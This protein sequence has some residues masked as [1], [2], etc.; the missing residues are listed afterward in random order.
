M[1]WYLAPALAVGR[2]EVNDRWPNRD[3]TSDGTIGDA[4]HQATRSDHNP[5]SRE[6]VDAW[7]MDVNG[8]NVWVVIDAFQDHPSAHYWIYDRQIATRAN[9]WRRQA[10]AGTNPHTQHVHF[11]VRQT[12]EA[13]QDR[14]SWGIWPLPEEDDLDATQAR[15]L[16][17]VHEALVTR[18]HA[19]AGG[20]NL[21]R[22]MEDLAYALLYG[23]PGTETT[24]VARTL[25]AVGEA[26][27][28]DAAEL[29]QI[30]G[31]VGDRLTTELLAALRVELADLPAD[32]VEVAAERA[33]RRVLG[34]LDAT[35]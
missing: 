19:W 15:Q 17:E 12:R 7:D 35:T 21:T 1:A 20:R 27:G 9:D 16:R 13:E 32:V 34:S 31:A 22:L 26:A 10:Y 18:K 29:E 6:S 4:A 11:S 28:L 5:N 23:L 14:R 33:V 30:R 8:V 24:W 25:R 3:K 2:A